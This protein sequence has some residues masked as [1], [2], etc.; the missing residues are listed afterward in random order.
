[1]AASGIKQNYGHFFSLSLFILRERERE[2]ERERLPS[3]LHTLS[4]QSHEPWDHDLSRNQELDAQATEL[5]RRPRT[6]GTFKQRGQNPFMHNHTEFSLG[7]LWVTRVLE[8]T[9]WASRCACCVR[10]AE[11]LAQSSEVDLWLQEL[12]LA[13]DALSA[14]ITNPKA[15]TPLSLLNPANETMCL[16]FTT[17]FLAVILS[18]T[19][20]GTILWKY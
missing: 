2:R 15:F 19:V 20:I 10:G 17:S 9:P 18:K 3:R 4:V 13:G 16:W 5:P 14:F 8:A 6:V 12:G 11:G 1:M 7:P